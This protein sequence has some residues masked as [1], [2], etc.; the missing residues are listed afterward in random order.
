MKYQPARKR[1]PGLPF[2]RFL[3]WTTMGH[4]ARILVVIVVVVV[5]IIIIIIITSTYARKQGYNLTKNTGMNM[6][7]NQ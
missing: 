4:A 2:K 5:V 3:D 6:Y 1:K 7:Q